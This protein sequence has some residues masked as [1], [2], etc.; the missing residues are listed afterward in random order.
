MLPLGQYSLI[1]YTIQ[2]SLGYG[3]RFLPGFPFAG[4]KNITRI[5]LQIA[6]LLMTWLLTKLIVF[7]KEVYAAR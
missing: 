5:L 1:A 6:G 3:R 4:L 7:G 2:A